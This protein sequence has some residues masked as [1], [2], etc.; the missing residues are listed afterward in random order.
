MA[1]E[2]VELAVGSLIIA[3]LHIDVEEEGASAPFLRWLEQHAGA[4]RLLI[5]GDLFEFWVGS[6]QAE[7]SGGREVLAALR[8]MSSAGT[9]IDIVPGNRDFLLGSGF[10][11][12]TGCRVH[13]AGLVGRLDSEG[14]VLFLHGDE[15]CTL[16]TSYQRLRRTIRSAPIRFLASHLPLPLTRAVG[17]R[18]RR[19]SQGAV[20]TKDPADMAQQPAECLSRAAE[21]EAEILVCGHA[22]RFRDEELGGLR[23]LVLDA[24]GG[25]RDTL[26]VLPGAEIAI[27]GSKKG[28]STPR[29]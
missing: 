6:A 17:R 7:T 16:D 10:E 2:Q 26:E 11:H 8:D 13:H 23:W 29:S 5:L 3:D 9:A 12:A 18:L 22:H 4:P 20:S 19:A 1:L 21:V 27:R 14:R 24:F 15:L 25:K 28:E